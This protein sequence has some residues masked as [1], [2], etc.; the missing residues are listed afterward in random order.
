MTDL[1]TLGGANSFATAVSGDTVV[2][3]SD[4]ATA[5]VQD[6]FAYDLRTGTMI[7]LGTFGGNTQSTAVAVS[8]EIV[9]GYASNGNVP[10]HAWAYN[11]GTRTATVLPTLGGPSA[12]AIGVNQEGVIV[13][14]AEL[15]VGLGHAA[16][17]TP[18]S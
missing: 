6:A 3:Y 8:G 12:T 7:D 17:W 14:N 11:L 4:T 2:G 13:G 9:C 1:G 10:N 15:S 5:G 18:S 16:A